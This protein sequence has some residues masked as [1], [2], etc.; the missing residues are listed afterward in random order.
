MEPPRIHSSHSD[1][2]KHWKEYIYEFIMLFM[3][4]TAGFYADNLREQFVERN[5]EHE[6]MQSLVEDMRQDTAQLNMVMKTL[7][8]FTSGLDSL[9]VA[10]KADVTDN[11]VQRIMYDLNARYL[12]LVPVVFSDR[13][14]SQLKNSGGMRL[15]RNKQVADSIIN[16]WQG[17]EYFNLIFGNHENFRRTAREFSLK[18]FDYSSYNYD[19]GFS[20]DNFKIQY[21][22]LIAKDDKKL[23]QEYANHVYVL[24]ASL[25]SLYIPVLVK[26]EK[27]AEQLSTLIKKEYHLR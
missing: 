17:I 6:Y 26:A 4:V 25:S 20:K 12:R 5:R 2:R 7:K 27:S 8:A 9:G 11:N 1:K 21:P 15:I 18:I 24:R 13:T 22:Q 19:S 23:L 3:A 10:C 16:Y 14:S